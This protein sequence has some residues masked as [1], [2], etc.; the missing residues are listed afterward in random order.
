MQ[1]AKKNTWIAGTAFLAIVLLAMTWFLLVAPVRA[2]AAETRAQT[3][4]TVVANDALQ[5]KLDKLKA[6]FANLDEYKADLKTLQK[7]IPTTAE[8]S[9]Y[10]LQLDAVAEKNE[11]TLI[12][13]TT[14]PGQA[15]MFDA[16]AAAPAAGQA[17]ST[18]VQPSAAPS[19][20]PSASAGAAPGATTAPKAPTAPA[21]FSAIPVTFTAVGTYEDVLA[22]L[23]GAQH[24]K[25]LLLVQSFAGTGQNK[26]EANGGV[27]ATEVGDLELLVGGY[28]WVLPDATAVAAE[29]AEEGEDAPKLPKPDADANPLVP[30]EGEKE[31]GN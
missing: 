9:S 13:V 5:L 31:P 23:D 11:V 28:L 27:P 8:L 26:T 10:L 24:T 6:D 12:N 3:A 25:R 17:A 20:S 7:Q 22:F 16:T 21:G 19:P 15:V 30:V 14:Q 29:D 4:T 18:E 1:G 2:Q